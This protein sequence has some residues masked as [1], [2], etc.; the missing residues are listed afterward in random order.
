MAAY[1]ALPESN[2]A[3]LGKWLLGLRVVDLHGHRPGLWRSALRDVLRAVD[4]LPA[5]NLL[6]VIL[7]LRL[8]ERTR[9]GDQL[10]GTRVV[11]VR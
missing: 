3:T 8:A 4:S 10:P 1:M 2:G 11:C 7:I 5:L 9:F 6:G